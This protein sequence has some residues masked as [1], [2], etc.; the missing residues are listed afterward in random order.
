MD[1]CIYLFPLD[2]LFIQILLYLKQLV[3]FFIFLSREK[4]RTQ[5]LKIV[6]KN[7]N[8]SFM[9]VSFITKQ[10][11]LNKIGYCFLSGIFP[12]RAKSVTAQYCSVTLLIF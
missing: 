9:I 6:P 5:D 3:L 12:L 7:M 4:R 8:K 1:W 2:N 10:K 11:M